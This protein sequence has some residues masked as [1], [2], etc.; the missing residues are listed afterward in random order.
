MS[1]A[2][3]TVLHLATNR[4]WTGSADPTIQLASAQQAHGHRVLL[5]V[6]PGDR[7]DAKAREAGLTVLDGFHLRARLAPLQIARDAARLRR[8]ARE[9]AVDVLH[10]H[11]SHDHWL[12]MLARPSVG[13]HRPPVAR[14]FHTLR[15]VKR[16]AASRRLYRRTG[17]ALA[18]SR[19]IE[20]RCREAGFVTE[21]VYWTPGTAD[22]A[23]FTGAGDARAV[24]DEFALGDAP[25]V[26]SVARLAPHR[27][28]DLLLAGFRGLLDS[29]PS[30]RL[31]LVG[32][33]EMRERLERLVAEHGLARQVSFAGYRDRDLPA[34]LAAADCFALMA[35]GSDDSCRAAL[36]AMAAARPV[37]ARALGALPEA[38]VHGETGLLVPDDRPES[39][40]SAL[41]PVLADRARARAM[42]TA[43]RRRAEQEFGA[44]RVVDI[45]ERAYRSML[46]RRPARASA[47]R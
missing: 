18:V 30:A 40:A 45:V 37:V 44:G 46:G 24:R 22:L 5:A 23:R 38:V 17:A 36:E 25:L 20:A 35:P 39:V 29:L 3:L 19:Q 9:H 43:G 6:P 41:R 47:R 27:G 32:K 11:H 12:A 14:T 16:D 31:L 42:G 13:G 10:A 33:G 28:H 1:T 2:A 4:W 15:A 34:V 21:R 7:F 8:A 26:V